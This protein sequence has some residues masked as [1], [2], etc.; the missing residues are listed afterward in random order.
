MSTRSDLLRLLT[1]A[2]ELEHGLACSYL[3][4]A[5]SLRQESSEGLPWEKISKTRQWAGQIYFV[6]GQEMMH[7]SQVWNLLT[8][9]GGTP[10]YLRPN[11]PQRSP[12]YPLHQR[13]ALE[14]FG[15]AALERFIRYETPLPLL[16]TEVVAAGDDFHSIGELYQQIEEAFVELPNSIVGDPRRQVGAEL[17]DFPDLVRVVDLPSAQAAIQQ[18]THQGEG[19]KTDREDCH[20][21]IFRR[22]QKEYRAVFTDHDTASGPARAV[23]SNP[24]VEPSQSYGA[25]DA[26]PITGSTARKTAALFDSLYSLMLRMLGHAFTGVGSD[27]ERRTIA[28]MAIAMMVSVMRPVGQ[29]VMMLP[30]DDKA[31]GL[32]A[33]PAF[34]LLRHVALPPDAGVALIVIRER[35]SELGQAAARLASHVDAPRRLADAA[36]RLQELSARLSAT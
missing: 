36:V 24:V 1:E 25:P 27:A 28:Q 21:G 14:P 4:A 10:Y 6:A 26:R 7:L 30:A 23:M 33:G 22:I 13:L 17:V 32:S 11:F 16:E 35:L 2:C 3:Y 8:A 12:Y 34:G 9:A 19:N 5:F 31:A 29:A 18:L 20:F 15:A